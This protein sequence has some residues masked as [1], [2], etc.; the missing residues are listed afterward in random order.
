LIIK[1][2]RGFTKKEKKPDKC[3]NTM[4]ITFQAMTFIVLLQTEHTIKIDK[5][6]RKEN[7][8]FVFSLLFL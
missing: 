5:R 4:K 8:N 7:S 2:K 1:L 3:H 6:N